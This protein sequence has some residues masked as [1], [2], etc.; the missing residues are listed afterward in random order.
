M[1]IESL[2]TK[3]KSNYNWDDIV[4][5]YDIDV[6]LKRVIKRESKI[7]VDIYYIGYVFDSEYKNHSIRPLYIVISHYLVI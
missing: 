1:V 2:K 5:V 3:N 6:K 4:Y 7:G